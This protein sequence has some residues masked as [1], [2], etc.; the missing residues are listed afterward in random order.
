VPGCPFKMQ[1]YLLSLVNEVCRDE[2]TDFGEQFV[3]NLQTFMSTL[4][5]E[6]SNPQR[7]ALWASCLRCLSDLVSNE[8]LEFSLTRQIVSKKYGV[9]VKE[10]E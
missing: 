4:A 5:R 2:G 9:I 8:I 1:I 7:D 10:L 3:E 6:P